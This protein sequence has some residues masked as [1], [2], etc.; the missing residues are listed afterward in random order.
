M[1]GLLF[2]RRPDRTKPYVAKKGARFLITSSLP[3]VGKEAGLL[4]RHIG[5]VR[6][7][8]LP[9]TSVVRPD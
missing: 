2:G 5:E 4:A 9:R 8:L 3:S 1:V 6:L 7:M